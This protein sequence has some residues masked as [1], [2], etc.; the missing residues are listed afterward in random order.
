[1][2]PVIDQIQK[3]NSSIAVTF[4]KLDLAD[5]DSVKQAAKE[6]NVKVNKLDVLIN[7]AGGRLYASSS[8]LS[9]IIR[10]NKLVI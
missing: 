7:N 3:E 10:A 8:T 1:V 6:I 9:G 5:L 2:Q 4:I